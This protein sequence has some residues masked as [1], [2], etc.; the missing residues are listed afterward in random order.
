SSCS[1]CS[2]RFFISFA[3]FFCRFVSI[4]VHRVLGVPF[5]SVGM[6][7]E[8]ADDSERA[9]GTLGPGRRQCKLC[10]TMGP[11]STHGAGSGCGAP[12]G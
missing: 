4:Q 3:S 6:A 12:L 5:R 9:A 7:S 11:R 1:R 8:T 2:H 10:Y